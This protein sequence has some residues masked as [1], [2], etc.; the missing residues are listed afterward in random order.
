MFGFFKK[1]PNSHREGL[2]D[3]FRRVV[4]KLSAAEPIALVAVGHG[5]NTA[6]SLFAQ[7]YG[8]TKQ[9]QQLSKDVQIQYLTSLTKAEEQF[10]RTDPP[11]SIGFALFKMWLGAVVANDYE[12][13]SEFGE[14]LARLS[15]MGDLGMSRPIAP[16]EVKPEV[17]PRNIVGNKAPQSPSND[18]DARASTNIG[19][20]LKAPTRTTRLTSEEFA[21]EVAKLKSEQAARTK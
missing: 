4:T 13:Q 10:A 3:D 19:V 11:T 16:S 1:V 2:R 6:N 21:A 8:N 9:F 20:V 17:S 15:R 18:V 7:R 14:E 12:L 5:V